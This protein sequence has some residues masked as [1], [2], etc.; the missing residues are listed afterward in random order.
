ML[1][2]EIVSSIK[3][4]FSRSKKA[5]EIKDKAVVKGKFGTRGGKI[6]RCE[7]CGV[8]IPQ[9]KSE[10]DHIEPI[11]PVMLAQKVMSFSMLYERTFCDDK[12][13]QVICRG[14]HKAKSDKENAERRK[15][16]KKEKFLVVRH[17]QGC[18]MQVIPI[19]NLKELEE[20]W[21][22][23]AVF[24]TMKQANLELKRRKKL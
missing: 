13:L 14:C 8:E 19:I 16:R 21:E 17:M 24:S 15:W 9:Y 7:I 4:S 23:L 5:K 6:V 18:R 1:T 20:Y 22:T 12:N 11:T 10:I 3:R 2:S